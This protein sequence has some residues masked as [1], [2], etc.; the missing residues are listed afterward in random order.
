MMQ[1][2]VNF[3]GEFSPFYKHKKGPF[4][5]TNDFL[6]KKLQKIIFNFYNDIIL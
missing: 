5:S 6:I 4:I 1:I 2:N 3:G